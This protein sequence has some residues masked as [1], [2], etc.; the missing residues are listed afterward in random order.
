MVCITCLTMPRK[1][2]G[3]ETLGDKQSF[4]CGSD[5]DIAQTTVKLASQYVAVIPLV[6][7]VT[8]S[9]ATLSISATRNTVNRPAMIDSM[10]AFQMEVK[11]P[12]KALD[13]DRSE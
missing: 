1:K 5:S 7:G 12:M 6:S 2:V 4:Y 11:S 10:R 13:L 9:G 3:K 8:H